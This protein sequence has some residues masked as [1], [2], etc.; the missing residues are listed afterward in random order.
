MRRSVARAASRDG[1]LYKQIALRGNCR[2]WTGIKGRQ[3]SMG[4]TDL[5]GIWKRL[6]SYILG[7]TR[8][9]GDG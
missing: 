1:Y 2:T 9:R 4:F 8:E 6:Q 5:L 7:S 3:G